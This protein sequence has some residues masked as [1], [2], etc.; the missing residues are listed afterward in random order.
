MRKATLL[1]FDLNAVRSNREMLGNT[2]RET[3]MLLFPKS[4][5]KSWPAELWLKLEA[6]QITGSFKVRGAL[7]VLNMLSPAQK[8]QGLVTVSSGNHAIATAYGASLHNCNARIYMSCTSDSYRISRA[9]SLGADI[10]LVPDVLSAFEEAERAVIS[11][12]R[13]FVHPFEGAQTS[14]GNA[15]L[16][17]ELDAQ[18]PHDVDVFVVAIGGGG[19]ASGVAPTIKM[20]RPGARVIGVEPE[21]APTLTLSLS[22]GSPTRLSAVETIA[23]S[24]APPMTGANTFALVR[25]FVD[26]VLLVTDEQIRRSSRMLLEELKLFIEPSGAAALAA[27]LAYPDRF[28][29]RRICAIVCGSNIGLNRYQQLVDPVSAEGGLPRR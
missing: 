1:P 21:G 15:S 13:V 19:L 5:A 28:A 9:R 4:D 2:I 7:S 27:I 22:R 6:M 25:D 17:L 10:R 3:P 8:A 14:L 29:A 18:L 16:S 12:G 23:D 26:E 24:L 20:L 11:E